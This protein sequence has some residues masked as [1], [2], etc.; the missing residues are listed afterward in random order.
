MISE[1]DI[2]PSISL[3]WLRHQKDAAR[4]ILISCRLK[5]GGSYSRQAPSTSLSRL[6]LDI[7]LTL[8]GG[9]QPLEL[10]FNEEGM[11]V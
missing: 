4:L 3:A 10:F 1:N 9:F 5:I 2:L 8:R 11:Y 6:F 7:A